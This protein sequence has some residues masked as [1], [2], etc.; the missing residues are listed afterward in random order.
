M[1]DM[2]NQFQSTE[3]TTDED[4]QLCDA[5]VRSRGDFEHASKALNHTRTAD[6]C[7]ARA[8]I[9][10]RRGQWTRA[11]DDYL[12]DLVTNSAHGFSDG[13]SGGTSGGSPQ[14]VSIAEL[15]P[16]RTGKQCRERYK[17]HLAP[18]ICKNAWTAEEDAKLVALQQVHGNSWCRIARELPG[19]AE[20]AVKNR[21]NGM[22]NKRVGAIVAAQGRNHEHMRDLVRSAA[23]APKART[24]GA[25]GPT[26]IRRN[27]TR[28]A[29]TADMYG[30]GEP[31]DGLFD[32]FRQEVEVEAGGD[33]EL[34]K[35][36]HIDTRT[37]PGHPG[38]PRR[39]SSQFGAD[40]LTDISAAAGDQAASRSRRQG[41]CGSL[42][43]SM[44]LSFDDL[45]ID[46]GGTPDSLQL[47]SLSNLSTENLSWSADD[48]AQT[49]IPL[50]ASNVNSEPLGAPMPMP[51]LPPM[52]S[53]APAHVA[54]STA[55]EQ[56]GPQRGRIHSSSSRHRCAAKAASERS[57]PA[58][59][60]PANG[61][62]CG[63]TDSPPATPPQSLAQSCL[64]PAASG[65]NGLSPTGDA[66]D[67]ARA[68][69]RQR[70]AEANAY[71][72]GGG[73]MKRKLA[74]RKAALLPLHVPQ[75]PQLDASPLYT[76]RL[77]GECAERAERSGRRGA[78]QSAGLGMLG[79]AT[80]QQQQSH[81]GASALTSPPAKRRLCHELTPLSPCPSP[82][83]AGSLPEEW[84]GTALVQ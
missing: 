43:V 21:W 70:V 6:E 10:K 14:W 39:H 38:H 9:V 1:I 51:T 34:L 27:S 17:N 5:V 65:V 18:G 48:T 55:F 42:D 67:E 73:G 52:P 60:T 2:N 19:R 79:F 3:W 66:A 15:I 29:R 84:W 12:R 78:L 11:E 83:T 30:I 33:N 41:L 37:R 4:I 59:V 32:A 36:N 63:S 49:S 46:A 35:S 54:C 71:N 76:G 44:D 74:G 16:G 26:R 58:P 24:A 53:P 23:R 7:A 81:V 40:A 57:A 45:S 62:V 80:G 61:T 72:Y 77:G 47:L 68:R 50:L 64:G 75:L 69:I 56:R 22:F 31:N 28:G 82:G 20:N 8:A 13:T 25:A